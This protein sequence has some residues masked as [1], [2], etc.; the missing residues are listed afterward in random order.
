MFSEHKLYISDALLKFRFKLFFLIISSCISLGTGSKDSFQEQLVL[1]FHHGFWGETQV[2][3]L[4]ALSAAETSR[5]LENLD[6]AEHG[7]W[8]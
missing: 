6:L 5:Q 3:R 8:H 7:G 2:I 1:S 4:P